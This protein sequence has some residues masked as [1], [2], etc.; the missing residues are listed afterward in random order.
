MRR[1]NV[2]RIAMAGWRNEEEI[3]LTYL[4]AQD[5]ACQSTCNF[6]F[7]FYT[8]FSLTLQFSRL[9]MSLNIWPFPKVAHLILKKHH[10]SDSFEFSI[11]LR[12]WKRE[13]NTQRFTGKLWNF[14]DNTRIPNIKQ[15]KRYH[16]N[17]SLTDIGRKWKLSNEMELHSFSITISTGSE[18]TPWKILHRRLTLNMIKH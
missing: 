13:R 8:P 6:S 14:L 18:C 7:S 3:N 1:W 10:F 4:F 12:E 11:R 9:E 15:R 16:S 17:V 5:F 2:Q